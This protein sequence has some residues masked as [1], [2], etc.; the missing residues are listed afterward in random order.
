MRSPAVSVIV[1][2]PKRNQ[3]TWD[4]PYDPFSRVLRLDRF[5]PTAG[6]DKFDRFYFLKKWLTFNMDY[7]AIIRKSGRT[8]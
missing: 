6:T 1:P 3:E 5:S 2:S 7:F 8:A 4:I